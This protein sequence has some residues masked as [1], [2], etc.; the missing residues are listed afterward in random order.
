MW[1]LHNLLPI[2]KPFISK[3][4]FIIITCIRSSSNWP[5]ILTMSCSVLLLMLSTKNKKTNN[6]S[7]IYCHSF[8]TPPH[9]SILWSCSICF[10][11]RTWSKNKTNLFWLSNLIVQ[12]LE[13]EKK[14]KNILAIKA[15][16]VFSMQN[17]CV[18][19]DLKTAATLQRGMV[20]KQHI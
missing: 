12:K 1:F 16:D 7:H 3:L 19:I 2:A 20:E 11:Y 5:H 6:G 18:H 9:P 10:D 14:N 13:R 8:Y 15:L 17:Q 4:Q